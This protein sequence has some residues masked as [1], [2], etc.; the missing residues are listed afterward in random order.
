MLKT[1]ALE[2][3]AKKLRLQILETSYNS[4]TQHIGSCLSCIDLLVAAYFSS[5]T[6]NP[7]KGDRDRIIFSKGHAALALYATLVE[8]GFFDQKNLGFFN[9][10]GSLLTEHP[11]KN[12]PFGI[13]ASTGSLGHGLSLGLGMA[14]G[15]R[16]KQFSSHVMVLMSDGECNEG[17]VWE[18]ALL[19][20]NLASNLIAVI[21][22]NKW[23]A[24]GRS[25]AITSLFSLTEKF[26]AF[27][28]DV[29]EIDGHDMKEITGA[30][31]QAKYSTKPF[32]I[33]GHTIKGKGVSFMENNNNWHYR[34]L[35][36]REYRLAKEELDEKCI[37]K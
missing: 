12:V 32:A 27:G 31:S 22:Y 25:N 16:I 26:K 11:S 4:K 21:D 18:A 3:I 13:E 6:V 5:F 19:A 35:S 15:L 17:S 24:T 7:T 8:K 34:T 14:A 29:L 37:C 33:I 20:P 10:E 9:K 23:Q 28:W 30:Y 2:K 1:L 36:D